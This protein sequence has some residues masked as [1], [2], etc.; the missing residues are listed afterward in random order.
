MH[1]YVKNP[2]LV[3][4]FYWNGVL[5]SVQDPRWFI[6]AIQ[7]GTITLAGSDINVKYSGPL[8]LVVQTANGAVDVHTGNF[9]VRDGN[10][11]ISVCSY[12]EFQDSYKAVKD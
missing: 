2:V 7:D 10:G 12:N 4:A 9:L 1:K 5:N 6:N 8:K 3:D 11:V